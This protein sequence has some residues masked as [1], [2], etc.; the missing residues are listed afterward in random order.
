MNLVW[1]NAH[2][3]QKTLL[4]VNAYVYSKVLR[5]DLRNEFAR[6]EQQKKHR[7]YAEIIFTIVIIF[8]A[9]LLAA[10]FGWMGLIL[11]FLLAAILFR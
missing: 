8:T 5:R 3:L 11:Y 6:L 1:L 10:S 7:T 9:A 4:L 2:N